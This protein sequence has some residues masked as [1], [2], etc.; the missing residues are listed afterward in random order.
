MAAHAPTATVGVV[1]DDVGP[2]ITI[3]TLST[4]AEMAD[5]G[6]VLQQIWGANRPMVGAELLLAI[7]HAG[8]YVAGAYDGDHL[9]GASFGFLARHLGQSAL[10]SH[11]TGVLP[12]VR[13]SGLGRAMKYHQRTWAAERDI[14]WITWTFD[15]LVRANAWFNLEVLGAEISE[16]L[17]NFY[18]SMSDAVNAGDDSDRLVAAWAVADRTRSENVPA[19]LHV[20]TPAD[21][22]AL[23]RTDPT[24]AE[25]W[26][27]DV[28]EALT[29]AM[30]R[31]A[32]V[33]GMSRDGDYLLKDS[34]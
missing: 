6:R 15:P 31:G 17:V 20:P 22:V 11:I 1:S 4:P 23:R 25:R 9:L 7:E 26:R 28:R 5:A 13:H 33:I 27:V 3:V 29:T 12:G 34:E 24:V 30:A 10:H 18:G 14:D 16:Y 8:G 2:D 32:T 21:I 19:D